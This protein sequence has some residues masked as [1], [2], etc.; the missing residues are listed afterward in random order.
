[1]PKK[2][3]ALTVTMISMLSA[4]VLLIVAIVS[5]HGMSSDRVKLGLAGMFT[6][7]FAFGV[8]T[9]T[10]AKRVELGVCFYG[11]VCRGPSCFR[12]W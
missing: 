7:V 12:E 9:L 3:V 10:I 4:A 2:H 6:F 8:A 5:L 1:M 11:G